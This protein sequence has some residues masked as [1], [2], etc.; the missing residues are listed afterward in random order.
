MNYLEYLNNVQWLQDGGRVLGSEQY[1]HVTRKDAISTAMDQMGF[2]RAQARLA[3]QNQKNALRNQ[4]FRGADMRQHARYNMIDTAYPR[5]KEEPMP[6]MPELNYD[7]EI[8]EEPIE[9]NDEFVPAEDKPFDV[10]L[11]GSFNQAFGAARKRGLNEFSWN[12]KR[13]TTELAK[14]TPAQN[15]QNT[16]GSAVGMTAT[17]T[18]IPTA[19]DDGNGN[20]KLRFR[21]LFRMAAV[22]GAVNMK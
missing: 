1:P 22:N 5:A 19:V 2:S 7:I 6:S 18:Y 10:S 13:Y 14:D 3:Y 9:I 16:V 4:G 17:P 21:D 15:T 11:M 8:E 12:G 20:K